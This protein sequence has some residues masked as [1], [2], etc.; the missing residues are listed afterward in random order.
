MGCFLAGYYDED[1]VHVDEEV[2]VLTPL[3]QARLNGVLYPFRLGEA[4]LEVVVPLST[5]LLEAV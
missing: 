4:I 2:L 1:V 5:G 3:V